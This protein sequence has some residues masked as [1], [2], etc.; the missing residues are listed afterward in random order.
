VDSTCYKC[1]SPI[2]EGTAFCPSCGAAQIRVNIPAQQSS[3]DS[4]TFA[5][6]TPAE[7]QPPAQPV[8][9]GGIIA[10][11]SGIDWHTARS[12][13]LI[14]GLLMGIVSLLPFGF[15]LI[16]G[17]GALAVSRYQ[18]RR[19]FGVTKGDG[20]KIGALSGV[21]GYVVFAIIAGIQYIVHPAEIRQAFTQAIQKAQVQN[22]NAAA[23]EIYQKFMTPEGMAIL[24]A[25]SMAVFFVGFIAFS[26]LGGMLTAAISRRDQSRL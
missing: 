15:L 21:I 19:G 14:A 2:Q 24:I 23:Q 22:P 3:N 9:L 8:N 1:G 5:P 13:V 16:I 10:T 4:P 7:M 18:R 20:A 6:G 12:G 25:L 17:G 11:Q 26:A